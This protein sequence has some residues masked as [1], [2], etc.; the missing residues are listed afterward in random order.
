MGKQ[1]RDNSYLNFMYSCNNEQKLAVIKLLE[2]C[3]IE[4]YMVDA[5]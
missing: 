1:S 2:W 3:S 4:L 5:K